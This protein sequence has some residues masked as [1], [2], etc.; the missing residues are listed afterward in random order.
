MKMTREGGG[1]WGGVGWG[2]GWGMA[3]SNLNLERGSTSHLQTSSVH[4]PSL[5]S[6]SHPNKKKDILKKLLAGDPCSENSIN[7]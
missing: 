7:Y 4:P 2:M 5:I 3:F 1:G 6:I